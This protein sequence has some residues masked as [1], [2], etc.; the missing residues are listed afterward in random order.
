MTS[1]RNQQHEQTAS[2]FDDPPEYTEP[3]SHDSS[4][5]AATSELL[6]NSRTSSFRSISEQ[7][8]TA[9]PSNSNQTSQSLDSPADKTQ[10]CVWEDVHESV[11]P[12]APIASEDP[13]EENFESTP[14]KG[15]W[16]LMVKRHNYHAEH[17][18]KMQVR[19]WIHDR[20][21]RRREHFRSLLG[22]TNV[23]EIFAQKM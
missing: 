10:D 1:T 13:W 14:P 2:V 22:H 19:K 5:A 21:K 8:G 23:V 16:G 12:G 18:A 4:S 6:L 7:Q 11:P 17:P 20:K 15:F 9:S 3:E